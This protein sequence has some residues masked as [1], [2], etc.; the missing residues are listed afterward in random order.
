MREWKVNIS[1][2]HFYHN[3][4]LIEEKGRLVSKVLTRY[5]SSIMRVVDKE[6]KDF[7]LGE[8]EDLIER[9]DNIT[10]IE[11]ADYIVTSVEEFDGCMSELYDFADQYR[12]W[13]ETK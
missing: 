12:I 6:D 9:F 2:S 5:T 11:E 3:D 13:I 7:I 8:I 4:I 1:F 10:G